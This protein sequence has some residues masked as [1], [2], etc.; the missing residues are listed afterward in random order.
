M[1]F[2]KRFRSSHVT[3]TRTLANGETVSLTQPHVAHAAPLPKRRKRVRGLPVWHLIFFIYFIFV[4]RLLAMTEMGVA[5]YNQRMEE[6]RAGNA[7]ER[8]VSYFMVMDPVS[9]KISFELRKS[10]R[11]W[12]KYR[13]AEA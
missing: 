3:S 12:V 4:M 9:E 5:T 8:A 11:A 2:F 10:I 6:M 13:S 7:V 1:P